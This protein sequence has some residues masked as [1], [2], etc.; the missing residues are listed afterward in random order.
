M[1]CR[2]VLLVLC[3]FSDWLSLSQNQLL[4][5]LLCQPPTWTVR[6]GLNLETYGPNCLI[7]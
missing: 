6:A 5:L 7:V 4:L 3:L 2:Q 1:P